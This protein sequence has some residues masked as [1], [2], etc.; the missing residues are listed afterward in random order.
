MRTRDVAG[1]VEAIGRDV[2]RFQPGD[3]V[4]GICEGC[5]AEH[6]CAREDK[7][8]ARPIGR[9]RWPVSRWTR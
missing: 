4:F 7:L 2:T 1:R 8:A 5:F 3:D 6:G 9:R